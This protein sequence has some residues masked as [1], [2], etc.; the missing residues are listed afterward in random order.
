MAKQ[1]KEKP[2]DTSQRNSYAGKIAKI[3]EKL[4]VIF[5]PPV[6]FMFRQEG[7]TMPVT[8]RYLPYSLVASA[9]HYNSQAKEGAEVGVSLTTL[10]A[11]SKRKYD[12]RKRYAARLEEGYESRKDDVINFAD[13]ESIAEHEED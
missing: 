2:E 6:K 12:E 3:K 11:V 5:E 4:V 8:I 7:K 9:E 1:A 13:L 10:T